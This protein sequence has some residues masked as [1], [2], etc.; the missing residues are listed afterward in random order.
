[1]VYSHFGD[2]AIAYAGFTPN[3]EIGKG[4]YF[5]FSLS[6]G[7]FSR[8]HVHCKAFIVKEDEVWLYDNNK[9][10]I[11]I[12]RINNVLG[13]DSCK[14]NYWDV[15]SKLFLRDSDETKIT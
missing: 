3:V 5:G 13:V 15:N 10:I 8:Y 11:T 14:S 4:N 6:A 9:R 7:S 1:M 12:S 2:F